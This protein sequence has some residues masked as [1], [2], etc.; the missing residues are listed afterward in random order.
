VRLLSWLAGAAVSVPVVA[1]YVA[2]G[3]VVLVGRSLL[4]VAGGTWRRLASPAARERDGATASSR[5]A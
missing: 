2:L 5:A 3:T 4:G 1:G